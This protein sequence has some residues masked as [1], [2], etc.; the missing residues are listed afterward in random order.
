[1][2]PDNL[3]AGDSEKTEWIVVPEILLGR[4]RQAAQIV[5]RSDFRGSDT[6]FLECRPIKRDSRNSVH[7]FS[8]PSNLQRIQLIARHCFFGLPDLVLYE[9][10]RVHF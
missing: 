5:E 3:V 6:G 4:E 2:K 1:M 8:K 7:E 10:F 9:R